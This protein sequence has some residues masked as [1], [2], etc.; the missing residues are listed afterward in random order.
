MEHR[1]GGGIDAQTN[2]SASAPLP[3]RRCP[4]WRRLGVD[5]IMC[6]LIPR[7]GDIKF[8]RWCRRGGGDDPITCV[9][10][11]ALSLLLRRWLRRHGGAERMYCLGV[12]AAQVTDGRRCILCWVC[13]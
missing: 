2:K 12:R 11:S 10:R 6:S 5:D 13:G 1:W 3:H 9:H 4:S 8:R 7:I